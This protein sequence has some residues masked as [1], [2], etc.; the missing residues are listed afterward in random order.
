VPRKSKKTE[1]EDEPVDYPHG[2]LA[3]GD[4]PP[5]HIARAIETQLADNPYRDMPQLELVALARSLYE[6][7]EQLRLVQA[8]L[9]ARNSVW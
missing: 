4:I 2:S 1:V 8:V 6:A 5:A 7:Q 3:H 9:M